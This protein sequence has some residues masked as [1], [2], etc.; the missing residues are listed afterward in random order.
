MACKELLRGH[1]IRCELPIR[2]YYQQIVLV[3][4]DDV[5]QVGY[6]VNSV[7]HVI[8]FNLNEVHRK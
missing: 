6:D 3:N 7:N 4:L 2:K 8:V 1:D 5:D